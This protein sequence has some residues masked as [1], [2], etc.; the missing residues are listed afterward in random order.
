MLTELRISHFALIDSLEL[1]FSPGFQVLTGETG[2]GKSLLVDALA[3]L[4]GGRASAGDV[5]SGAK[6]AVLEAVFTVSDHPALLS[7]L[8][9]WDLSSDDGRE[10]CL[11]RI[12]SGG[13]GRNR[14]Y[15]NGTPVPLN[16]MAELGGWLVD[17]HGQHEQQ[18]L[19]S[20]KVQLQ[21]LDAFGGLLT[22]RDDYAK[23]YQR[24]QDLVR[25]MED[26]ARRAGER[27]EREEFLRFQNEEL[28]AAHVMPGEDEALIREHRTLQ[29]GG[30][31]AE[32]ANQAYDLLYRNQGAILAQ[33]A[34][35][36]KLV[37][38]LEALDETTRRWSEWAGGG[39]AQAEELMMAV[40]RYTDGFEHD[41][42]RL[43]QIDE[44]L[45]LL[46]GLKKK[47]REP[48]EGLI[49]RQARMQAELDELANLDEH[50]ET[51]QQRVSQACQD[52]W[53]AGRKLSRSRHAVAGKLEK[54]IATELPPLKL[55]HAAFRIEL[56]TAS[57]PDQAGP[58]GMDQ[59]TFVFCANPGESL[60]P[61][62]RVA[63]G[64]EL[65]RLMLAMKTVLA[66]VDE[67]PV[68]LFDEVDTGVGGNVAAAMG[69]RLHA[70]GRTHQVFCITHL[71]QIA[72]QGHHH[73]LVEKSGVNKRTVITVRRLHA[74]DREEEIARMLGGATITQTVKK[75]A[76]EMLKAAQLARTG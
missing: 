31:I 21:V 36:G 70:L 72:A 17:I 58:H 53:D 52:T 33:L 76:G 75:A 27:N 20:P 8:E 63:S 35:V 4:L 22:V 1:E 41:P 74:R 54:R 23:Q 30:R 24:W 18:S 42:G 25:D 66:G 59:I 14:M 10:L 60:Q 65:S 28:R 49:A 57:Q 71:P 38:E 7:K 2:A 43:A 19:L 34:E 11:R 29:N 45:A 46:Q 37:R 40:R 50:M 47:Y 26:V 44:R 13:E 62:A 6:E 48:L 55:E 64:G 12:V 56:T 61:L 51:L 9:E 5:R 69:Q 68:L 16:R 67:V 39:M 73:Y 3:L 32:L 15:V